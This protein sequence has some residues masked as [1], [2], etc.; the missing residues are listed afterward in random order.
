MND[1][2][3]FHLEM[4]TERLVR[5]AGLEPKRRAAARGRAF[6]GVETHKEALRDRRGLAWL[7][8]MSLDLK[9]MCRMLVRYPALTLLGGPA[10]APA[11]GAG[12]GTF[13]VIKRAT[14]SDLPLPDGERIVGFTYWDLVGNSQAFPSPYDLLTWRERL[15][16]V[17]EVGGFRQW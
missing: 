16:S 6:G 10:M 1:E 2:F 13:V 5:D 17:Q 14:H 11:I 7:T 12:A 9:L 15:R 3:R 4:E 8:V